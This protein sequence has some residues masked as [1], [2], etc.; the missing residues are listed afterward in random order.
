MEAQIRAVTEDWE[1]RRSRKKEDLGMSLGKT[2][3]F[4]PDQ[5]HGQQC[6]SL[7]GGRIRKSR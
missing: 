7:R 5:L 2:L 6:H 1:T 3:G 4:S